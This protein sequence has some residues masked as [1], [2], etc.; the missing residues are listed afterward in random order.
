MGVKSLIS[1]NIRTQE[2]ATNM[3]EATE[4]I[5]MWEGKISDSHTI[6]IKI[7][8]STHLIP[9]QTISDILENKFHNNED[10]NMMI[11]NPISEHHYIK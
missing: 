10:T 7:I 6:R 8:K 9:P 5:T 2:V 11:S 1:E 4:A 3:T